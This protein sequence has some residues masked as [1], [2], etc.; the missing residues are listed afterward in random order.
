M[1]RV[2][3]TGL[4]VVSALGVGVEP[5]WRGLCQARS[6]IRRVTLI[7]PA[8]V[9]VPIA[10]EVPEF[11]PERHCA[12]VPI[13]LLD[14]FS[15]FA[16]C[17]AREAVADAA[18][19]LPG[20][21]DD[22]A[23][24]SLGTG[25]GGQTTLDDVH[26]RV[27]AE[28]SKR[29]WPLGI[30]RSMN[31]AAASHVGMALGL[32]GPTLCLSTACASAGHAIGEAFEIV[33]AGRAD[34]MLAG[35]AEAPITVPVMLAWEAMRVLAR[36]DDDPARACRPFSRDRQGIVLAEAAGVI[37][38]EAWDR[39][40]ERGAQIRAELAGYG[41]TADAEHITQVALAGPV[42]ATRL[43]LSQANLA[44][45]DI[46]YV[47]AHGTGTRLNDVTETAVIK[48]AFGPHASRL[49]VSSTKSMHGHAIGASGGL[50][51]IATVLA[52][53]HGVAP[54]T[55][56]YTEVDPQCDL[57]YVPNAA[58]SMT[59]RAAVSNSFAF[60]G[61]NAVLVV[62]AA[63]QPTSIPATAPKT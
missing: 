23:G 37:V 1:R 51:L 11:D 6:G 9:G 36:G 58:R 4:G 7:D 19:M 45:E 16:I 8:A 14:R 56:H 5:F 42:R 30:P 47:N 13:G 25:G 18:L 57:D 52:V 61:L 55:A 49:A 3:I 33:R 29:A 60:G 2:A 26:R 48:E 34:V 32:R 21:H 35:G 41:A 27:Y 63:D 53:Q 40:V 17:A 31:S 62:K 50:E 38:L 22:R 59:I 24:V 28:Q 39:A 54:P 15:Q 10:G 20:E 12:G 46:D 43:A 44:P